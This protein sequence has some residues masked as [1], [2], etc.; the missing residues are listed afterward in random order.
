M[1]ERE[2]DGKDCRSRQ[3]EESCV[4]E[5][6]RAVSITHTIGRTISRQQERMCPRPEG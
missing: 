1:R 5:L 4:R 6:S 2:K 3:G